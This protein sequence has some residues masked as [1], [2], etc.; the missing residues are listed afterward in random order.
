MTQQNKNLSDAYEVMEEWNSCHSA[1][2]QV[3]KSDISWN[4]L[5]QDYLNYSVVDIAG[6]K[7]LIAET[8]P[9]GVA[10]GIPERGFWVSLWG[11]ISPNGEGAFVDELEALARSK[12]KNRIS[13]AADEFHFLPGLPNQDATS[14][15]LLD[16]FKAKGFTFREVHDLVGRLDTAA[17]RDYIAAGIAIGQKNNW[18]FGEAKTDNEFD[19]LEKFLQKEFPGRW[20]REFQTWR[21]RK[22]TGRAYWMLLKEPSGAVFGFS[23]LA[24]RGRVRPLDQGWTPGPIRLP[25]YSFP[26]SGRGEPEDSCL[27]PIGIASTERGRGAGKALLSLSLQSLLDLG[28]IRNCIDWT[29]LVEYYAPLRYQIPRKYWNIWK[30]LADR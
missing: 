11:Q 18:L 26:N 20:T 14:I 5:E 21:H 15:H 3:Y 1:F 13:M 25:L 22:D 29:D 16:A 8:T 28:A 12:N 7:S 19:D 27:G 17:A 30:D 2:Y 10:A 24:L 9:R 23:R 4:L 6:V